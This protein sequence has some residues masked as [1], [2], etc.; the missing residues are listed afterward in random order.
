MSKFLI[1]Q[2]PAAVLDALG[3][4]GGAGTTGGSNQNASASSKGFQMA[5]APYALVSRHAIC[6]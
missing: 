4:P 6:S 3:T 2:L 1:Q 5:L